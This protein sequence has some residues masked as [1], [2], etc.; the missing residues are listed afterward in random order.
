MALI[1]YVSPLRQFNYQSLGSY[2]DVVLQNFFFI[3]FPLFSFYF[4]NIPY[5]IYYI[6]GFVALGKYLFVYL[7]VLSFQPFD[8]M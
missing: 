7:S 5:V 8:Y 3:P 6:K 4:I 1:F 2:H